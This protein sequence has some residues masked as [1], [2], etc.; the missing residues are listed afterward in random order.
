MFTP[1]DA[2]PTNFARRDFVG[3][4]RTS[5]IPPHAGIVSVDTQLANLVAKRFQLLGKILARSSTTYIDPWSAQMAVQIAHLA[6]FLEPSPGVYFAE[7][8]EYRNLFTGG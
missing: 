6:L 2:K 7:T 5:S 3:A 8:P 1:K 4:H